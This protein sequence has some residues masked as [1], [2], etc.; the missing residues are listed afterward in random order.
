ME[1]DPKDLD[2]TKETYIHILQPKHT[3]NAKKKRST[4]KKKKRTKN[5]IQRN[6][7]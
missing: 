4:L 7:E 2:N 5:N 1:I 6:I 3:Y